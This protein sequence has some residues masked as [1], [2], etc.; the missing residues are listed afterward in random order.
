MTHH[1]RWGRRESVTFTGRN[2]TSLSTGLWLTD[3]GQN[4]IL[5]PLTTRDEL[6]NC[7]V[8]IPR[9]QVAEVIERLRQLMPG[10][11]APGS[12]QQ[13]RGGTVKPRVV[14]DPDGEYELLRRV[15]AHYRRLPNG[16]PTLTV[17]AD[18]VVGDSRLVVAR[19]L[20]ARQATTALK[21]AGFVKRAAGWK[22][23]GAA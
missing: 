3:T 6:A 2:G 1:I 23:G 13:L 12:R 7:A 20:T 16:G 8:V 22:I 10:E 4:V 9:D 14:C 17:S 11:P 19:F 5:R 18:G 15:A 21:K